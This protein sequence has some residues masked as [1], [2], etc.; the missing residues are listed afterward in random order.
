MTKPTSY[1]KWQTNRTWPGGGWGEALAQV[2]KD[3]RLRQRDVADYIGVSLATVRKWEDGYALPD[4]DLWPKVEE[5][6]GM[7]VPDPRVPGHTPAERELIDTMLLMIDEIRLLR[8]RIGDLRADTASPS[9]NDAGQPKLLDVGGAASYLGMSIGSIRNLIAGR[10]VV[11]Y[12]VGRRVMFKR[13]DFDHFIDGNK[14]ELPDLTPW[15]LQRRRG[16]SPRKRPVRTEP[17][18]RAPK[19]KRRSKSEIA[20]V[21]TTIYELAD[22]WWGEGSARA[23]LD[24]AGVTLTRDASG[25]EVF[26]YGDLVEWM[27]GHQETFHHW[28]DEFDTAQCSSTDPEGDS[29]KR[30]NEAC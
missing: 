2:R 29:A 6:M 7:P 15:Q 25:Q 9:P 26:R 14:R 18:S 8:V 24:R 4:R 10:T 3:Q 22:R 20:E 21:R 5:A 13:E 1:Q 27:E 28:C 19:P 12:K 17:R 23:L 30:S 11:H 16:Q